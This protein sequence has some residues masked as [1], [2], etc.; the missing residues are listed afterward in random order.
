VLPAE[1]IDL[2]TQAW[3]D[4]WPGLLGDAGWLARLRDEIPL[5]V[6]EYR[7]GGR[8][9]VAPRLVAWHGDP[10]TGYVY[11]GVRH[12]P[13][14]WTPG[15]A[16]A[17]AEVEAA[18]RLTFNAVLANYYRDGQDSVGWHAD[19]EPEVGPTHEDRWVAS[20][21]FGARRRFVLRHKKMGARHAFELGG[22]DLLVM[23]GL[24]QSWYRHALL[25]TT[26]PVE[27]RLNLTFR[28]IVIAPAADPHA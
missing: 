25:K 12:E 6:E 11:S 4:L 5:A 27:P 15:L 3:L 2:G 1:R 24:T 9:V 23:R 19:D 22:G 16:A 17:R 26:R 7:M 28:H 13:I 14:A 21:S 20:L 18:T 10:G 8:T